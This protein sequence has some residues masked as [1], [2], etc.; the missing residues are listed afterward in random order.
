MSYPTHPRTFS[1]RRQNDEQHADKIDS[2]LKFSSLGEARYRNYRL[3]AEI[4]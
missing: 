2:R 4:T 3:L 1:I